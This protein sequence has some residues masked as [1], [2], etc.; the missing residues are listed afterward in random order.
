[1]SLCYT[2]VI[3]KKC[4][5]NRIHI[6]SITTTQLPK[7]NDNIETS[8]QE[9]NISYELNNRENADNNY[10]SYNFPLQ[11]DIYY[12]P[13][14]IDNVDTINDSNDNNS[15]QQNIYYEPSNRAIDNYY[16]KNNNYY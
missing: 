7:T 4:K 2:K 8:P 10:D 5:K 12:E 14:N 9:E 15:Q 6:E 3:K 1:M 11:E 13:P 16:P